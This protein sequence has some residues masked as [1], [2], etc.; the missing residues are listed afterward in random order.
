MVLPS[1]KC[2]CCTLSVE[3]SLAHLFLHY[4]FALACWSSNSLV[5]SPTDPYV[6]L[7]HLKLQLGIAFFMDVIILMSWCI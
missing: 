3:E 1:Y 7:E 6:A 2:V 4:S 5:I